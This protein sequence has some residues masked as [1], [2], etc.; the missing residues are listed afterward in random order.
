[1]VIP[2]HDENPVRRVPVVTYL[3]IAL[4]VAVFLIEPISRPAIGS[5]DVKTA[6]ACKQEAFFRHYAAIPKELVTNSQLSETVLGPSTEVPNACV[7]GPPAYRKVP[8]VSAV[9]AMFLHGGWV[10]LIGNM[11]FLFVF[12]NNVEDRLGRLRFL[13][14]YL[15]WGL[16]ATYA[17]ALANF[18]STQVVVG[19][20]GAIA[21][22][23]GAYLVLF[24]RARVTSLVPFFFF[25]PARLPAWLVLGSWFLLQWWY[26]A[27]AGLTEGSG[28]AYLAHVAGFVAGVVTM[29]ALRRR[30]RLAW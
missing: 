29:V 24:P 11:L 1:M 5:G 3:L 12:G 23:L 8:I 9:Y 2:I 15:G 19:A 7:V 27:G 30:R 13:I 26:S 18:S 17:F 22:V 20:S 21:G 14:A 10:H 25:F 6:Q 4:N 16:V 28:V